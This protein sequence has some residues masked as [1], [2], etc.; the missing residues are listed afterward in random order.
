M[1]INISVFSL[2]I[3]GGLSLLLLLLWS[4]SLALT[5]A[6]QNQIDTASFQRESQVQLDQLQQNQ[7]DWLQA[8]FYTLNALA[9]SA[10]ARQNF[11]SLLLDYYQRNPSIWAVNLIVFDGEGK[12]VSDSSKPGCLQ[13]GQMRL[14]DLQAPSISSCRRSLH[15][16]DRAVEPT[17][18]SGR[19]GCCPKPGSR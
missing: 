18:S 7:R 13:P 11:Q 10:A 2:L 14:Q 4:V 16:S 3:V 8:Q 9:E 19:R 17:P 6:R 12:P 5:V 15:S 1:R